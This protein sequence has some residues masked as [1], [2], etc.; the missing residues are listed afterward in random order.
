MGG[1][2]MK[3]IVCK[4]TIEHGEEYISWS[5]FEYCG[6]AC[7]VD[8]LVEDDGMELKVREDYRNNTGVHFPTM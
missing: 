4:S 6:T 8:Q 5:G 7:V 1:P 2:K 3:C